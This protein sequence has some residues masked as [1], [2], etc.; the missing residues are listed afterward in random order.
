MA[1]SVW[2]CES[3]THR[4]GVQVMRGVSV[5]ECSLEVGVVAG[6]E[7]IVSASRMNSAIVVF[8]NDVN[9]A[10][11]LVQKSIVINVF[12]LVS[13][14]RSP[15]KKIVLSNVSPFI[16]DEALSKGLSRYG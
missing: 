16:P 3:L 11:K 5:E 1:P 9:R 15:S 6:R 13:L 2:L 10:N 4:H 7:S 14:L 8:H 12:T